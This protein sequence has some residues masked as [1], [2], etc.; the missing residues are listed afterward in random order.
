[1][2]SRKL[3]HFAKQFHKLVAVSSGS[4]RYRDSPIHFSRS[5]LSFYEEKVLITIDVKKYKILD[6]SLT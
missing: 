6:V 1:M 2:A 4:S 3:Q 5:C